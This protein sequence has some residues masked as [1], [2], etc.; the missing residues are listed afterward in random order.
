MTQY[1]NAPGK[2]DCHN[3]PLGLVMYDART[4]SGQ[5]GNLCEK[6]FQTMTEGRLGVG[7]G[8]KYERETHTSPWVKT[9]G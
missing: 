6:G 9:E 3:Q 8:Q 2:C 7:W 5:W 4:K 1:I